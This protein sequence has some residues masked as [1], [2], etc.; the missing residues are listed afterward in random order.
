MLTVRPQRLP[1]AFLRR[2]PRV[3]MRALTPVRAPAPTV[4]RSLA[5]GKPAP[6]VVAVAP[7]VS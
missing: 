3:T 7:T 5:A 4:Q 2:P 6:A 1:A